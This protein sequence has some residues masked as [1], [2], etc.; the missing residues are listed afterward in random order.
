MEYL[1]L[2][3]QIK[4]KITITKRG[5]FIFVKIVRVTSCRK[6]VMNNVLM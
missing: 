2:K 4:K 1:N 6:N 3:S 5:T